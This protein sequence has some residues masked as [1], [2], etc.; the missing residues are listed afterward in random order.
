M[1]KNI[2][3]S[4]PSFVISIEYFNK[5]AYVYIGVYGYSYQESGRRVMELFKERGWTSIV[6]DILVSYV[7]NFTSVLVAAATGGIAVGEINGIEPRD[8]R[9]DRS[10]R[11]GEHRC[12]QPVRRRLS[13]AQSFVARRLLVPRCRRRLGDEEL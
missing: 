10:E 9:L 12:W 6:S 13:M 4:L 2:Q 11:L 5:W 1:R 3:R 8:R 7:L